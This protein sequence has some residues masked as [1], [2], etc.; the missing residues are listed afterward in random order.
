[1]NTPV[2]RGEA[3]RADP[4]EET[5]TEERGPIMDASIGDRIVVEAAVLDRR[6]REGVVVAVLGSRAA[7]CY[8]VRWRDGHE[9]IVYPGPDA[10][11]HQPRRP[12]Q[13]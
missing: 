13:P 4:P 3:T 1:M 10:R 5:Q 2:S 8:Q 6:R 11:V 9:S 12:D 7:P